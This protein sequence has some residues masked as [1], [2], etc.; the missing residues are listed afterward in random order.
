MARRKRSHSVTLERQSDG[1]WSTRG[2][3]DLGDVFVTDPGLAKT[4]PFLERSPAELATLRKALNTK[5]PPEGVDIRPSLLER[6]RAYERSKQYEHP[7]VP[8]SIGRWRGKGTKKEPYHWVGVSEKT[9]GYVLLAAL[10]VWGAEVIETDISNWWST[11]VLNVGNDLKD[12]G[13]DVLN[14]LGIP[15]NLDTTGKVTSTGP[16]AHATFFSW[17]FNQVMIQGGDLEQATYTVNGLSTGFPSGGGL[18]LPPG[19]SLNPPF[20]PGAPAVITYPMDIDH[21]SPPSCPAGY[22]PVWNFG[23]G[24]WDCIQILA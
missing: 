20:A 2:P 24:H 18:A 3:G 17:L 19:T 15:N 1:S 16:R 23:A 8:G 12:L 13:A 7:P 6:Y 9:A 5:V 14:A 11:S 4:S 21:N 22:S 10:L